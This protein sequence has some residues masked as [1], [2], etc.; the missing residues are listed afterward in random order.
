[1]GVHVIP[2][3]EGSLLGILRQ[4]F[5]SL[6]KVVFGHHG[7]LMCR[8]AP[9]ATRVTV[10]GSHY[11]YLVVT[12]HA[13]FIHLNRRVKIPP[14]VSTKQ[15][16]A[17]LTKIWRR[18]SQEYDKM[19][20]I[21]RELGRGVREKVALVFKFVSLRVRGCTTSNCR[22]SAVEWVPP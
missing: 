13:R 22:S 16:A 2:R 20:S 17:G 19:P 11:A 1:M 15:L 10:L 6:S 12:V 8:Q 14:G 18:T 4:F 5:Y 9:Q 21:S 7:V 3:E